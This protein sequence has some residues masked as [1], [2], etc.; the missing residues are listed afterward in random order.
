MKFKNKIAIITG[1]GSGIGLATA[2]SFAREGANVVICGR[3]KKVIQAAKRIK[4]NYSKQHIIYFI[5][6][7]SSETQVI[8]LT[9]NIYRQFG[10]IDILVNCAG[11]CDS[12]K[13][14]S[15][16]LEQWN[17]MLKNNLTNS[18]LCSKHV[19]PYMKKKK[20]GKIINVSSIAGRFRSKLAGIHYTCSKA[21]LIAFTKQLAYEVAAY[22]INVNAICPS[23]TMT[24]MLKKFL[25]PKRKK[26]LEGSIP[27]GYIALPKQQAA[28][29]LFL[30]SD[31]S[32]YMTGS[33][34]DVNGG[35]L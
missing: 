25:S 22:K 11:V 34:V 8:N 12:G 29:I 19:L 26:A 2:Q 30:A 14:E 23:Q 16:S 18:F 15:I 35:Q 31:D 1:G 28:V 5:L 24:A 32:N 6:D 7:V 27:L 17:Y 3:S 10:R 4:K 13:I 21:A 20:Y 33:V 9:S